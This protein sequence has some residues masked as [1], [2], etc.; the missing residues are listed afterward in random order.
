[1]AAPYDH[2]TSV[3]RYATC[4]QAASGNPQKFQAKTVKATTKVTLKK[5]LI[6]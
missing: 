6:N 5:P 2:M 1:M 4:D 3:E